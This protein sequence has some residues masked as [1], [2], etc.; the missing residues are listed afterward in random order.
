MSDKLDSRNLKDKEDLIK[1]LQN[2]PSDK[3]LEIKITIDGS[4]VRDMGLRIPEIAMNGAVE[5][6]KNYFLDYY[7]DITNKN[8]F[9]EIMREKLSQSHIDI[10]IQEEVKEFCEGHLTKENFDWLTKQVIEEK[11][12]RM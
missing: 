2:W 5:E 11:I 12:R 8:R 9:L 6:L 4:V 10:L 7:L 1:K 3:S